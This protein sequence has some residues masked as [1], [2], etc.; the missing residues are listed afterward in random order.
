MNLRFLWVCKENEHGIFYSFTFF[1]ASPKK[2][3]KKRPLRRYFQN[4]CRVLKPAPKLRVTT[5]LDP[6]LDSR[7]GRS[8]CSPI[9]DEEGFSCFAGMQFF[10][11]KN[12]KIVQNMGSSSKKTKKCSALF[13]VFYALHTLKQASS[14]HGIKKPLGF[15]RGFL[16][17][18]EGRIIEP[19]LE[20]FSVG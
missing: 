15:P 12:Q 17:S 10:P 2:N 9:L 1:F 3:Q 6:R 19:I 11:Q 20:R 16:C 7:G 8:F 14:A 13:R 5:L 18:G 4:R